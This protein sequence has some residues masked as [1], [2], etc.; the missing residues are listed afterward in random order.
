MATNRK[1]TLK[2]I[3][4]WIDNDEGLYKWWKSSRQAKCT[5]VRENRQEL[6]ACILRCLNAPPQS[7]AFQIPYNYN[8]VR[9]Y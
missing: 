7:S 6:E 1:L 5:F 8:Q 9:S 2:D 3:E 4:Q